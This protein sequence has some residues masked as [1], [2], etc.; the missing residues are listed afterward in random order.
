M[1][2]LF[3]RVVLTTLS[4]LAWPYAVA[5]E[6]PSPHPPCDG[7]ASP[8]YSAMSPT[9]AVSLWRTSDL[10]RGG[11]V[12]P[13]CLGWSG[14]SLSVAALAGEIGFTGS[15]NDLLT[16]FGA[17][18]S[19][20]SIK[21]WSTTSK[22]WYPLVTSVGVVAAPDGPTTKPSFDA[23]DLTV[24]KDNY[25]FETSR[26]SSR[27]VYRLRVLVRT[28]NR[29]VIASENVTAIRAFGFTLFEPSALQYVTFLDQRGDKTWGY[30]QIVRTREGTSRLAGGSE[31]SYL[32]RLAALYRYM[33]G[34][35]T[36]TEPPVAR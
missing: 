1:T 20:P 34:I 2:L 26:H 5:A 4:A 14:T 27:T 32:N 13:V 33:A 15:V 30:Y 22:G 23:I 9:P 21:Y 36:D 12:P 25:Y 17:L 8:M 18:A 10:N 35:P 3:R 6:T 7:P 31:A 24:G 29:A 16:R 11:W 19:Y 28:A